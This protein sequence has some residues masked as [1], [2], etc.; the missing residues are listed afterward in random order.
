MP[1]RDIIVVGASAGGIE[2]LRGL[3]AGLPRDLQATLFVVVHI[4]PYSPS[5][6]PSILSAAGPLPA[7]HPADGERV[8]PG[9]I[10]VTPPDHHLLI[11]GA[12][13]LVRRGPK[14]NRFRP[15]VDALFRSA[16][17]VYGPRVIGVVLSD[18]LDDGSSGL[19]TVKRL[20]AWRS[21]KSLQKRRI[22]TCRSA[23]RSS[24]KSI[25]ACD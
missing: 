14:E 21:F 4:P 5:T 12:A 7:T 22:P 17:Y 23:P 19:W 10:Y 18:A 1:N 16:A 11:E 8:R 13:V 24:W 15:S 3:A 25:T 6:L 20:G 2:A 9:H